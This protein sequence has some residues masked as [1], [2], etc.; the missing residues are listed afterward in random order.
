MVVSLAVE[1]IAAGDA[2]GVA[3]YAEDGPT[4][5]VLRAA[6]VPTWLLSYRGGADPT[7]SARLAWLFLKDGCWNGERVLSSEW[8]ETSTSPSTSMNRGYGYWWW[9]NGEEPLL[10]SVAVVAPR[11]GD[12]EAPLLPPPLVLPSLLLRDGLLD[13]ARI[14]LRRAASR[15]VGEMELPSDDDP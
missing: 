6:G 1:A 4:R 11:V 2:V 15:T 9:L 7:L 10:D 8:I 14:A 3:A 5:E 13:A 12:R